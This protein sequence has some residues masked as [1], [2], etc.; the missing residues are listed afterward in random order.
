[1]SLLNW[2]LLVGLT[3]A[4]VSFSIFKRAQHSL[5]GVF[6]LL[7]LPLFWTLFLGQVD[8]LVVLGLLALPW[9][10]PLALFKPQVA[11]FALGARRS[12]LIGALVT[13]IFSFVIWGF[14]PMRLL[15]AKAYYG[16]TG[17]VQDIAIGVWGIPIALVLLWFSRGD[18]DMLMA[19]GVF[20][21]LHL[22]PF[23]LLPLTPAIA[24]LKPPAAAM[25][26][27]LSWLPLGANWLGPWGW[28]LGWLFVIWVWLNLAAHR[29]GWFGMKL[30]GEAL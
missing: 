5:S 23:N 27:L 29:Y 15:T 6:A 19:A 2:P 25:A 14:W 9:S 30:A 21:T 7:T 10:A 17:Y 11:L 4:A 8:G 26:C 28:W 1:M 16:S 18:M 24:R 13:V 22:I 20:G 3:L 12:Y